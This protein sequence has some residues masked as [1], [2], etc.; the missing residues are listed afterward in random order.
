MD[1][2]KFLYLVPEREG[3]MAASGEEAVTDAQLAQVG[4]DEAR[5]ARALGDQEHGGARLDVQQ[6]PGRS[7]GVVPHL[8]AQMEAQISK[9][10]KCVCMC[11]R[12]LTFDYND[13][14]TLSILQYEDIVH[15]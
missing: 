12:D 10:G 4:H 7:L 9:L 11:T 5:R 15:N 6:H 8:H 2:G 13:A 14:V 1:H 3:T